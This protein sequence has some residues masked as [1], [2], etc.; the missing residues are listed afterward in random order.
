M[1][2][3]RETMDRLW[4]CLRFITLAMLVGTSTTLAGCS[5]SASGDVGQFWLD[6]AR[7][8]LAAWLL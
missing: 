7:S 2:I 6:L 5:Q 8:A 1:R 3:G 4:Q